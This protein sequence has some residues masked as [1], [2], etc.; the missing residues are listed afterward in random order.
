MHSRPALAEL[1]SPNLAP[2]LLLDPVVRI[3]LVRLLCFQKSHFLR[4]IGCQGMT[5]DAPKKKQQEA[6]LTVISCHLDAGGGGEEAV[7]VFPAAH[8]RPL[9][10]VVRVVVVEGVV[11]RGVRAVLRRALEATDPAVRGCKS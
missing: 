11:A 2:F 8:A 5:L 6:P 3:V 10:E 9:V 7:P 1:P 4:S